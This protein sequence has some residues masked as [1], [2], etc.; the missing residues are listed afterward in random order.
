MTTLY[1]PPSANTLEPPVVA[2]MADTNER[3][4]PL[5]NAYV[6]HVLAHVKPD[7]RLVTSAVFDGSRLVAAIRFPYPTHTTHPVHFLTSSLLMTVHSQAMHVLLD[8]SIPRL[9]HAGISRND[10]ELARTCHRIVVARFG[11]KFIQP[12]KNEDFHFEISLNRLHRTKRRLFCNHS[13]RVANRIAGY[14]TS[15]ICPETE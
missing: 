15:A 11:V 9:Q 3:P 4:T 1:K 12:Q 5:D 7:F 8:M 13:F 10:L 14:S 2:R 6:H